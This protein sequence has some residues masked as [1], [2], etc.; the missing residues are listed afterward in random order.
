MA[1]PSRYRANPKVSN[2]QPWGYEVICEEESKDAVVVEYSSSDSDDIDFDQARVLFVKKD[3]SKRSEREQPVTK[4]IR[5]APDPL[6]GAYR[7]MFGPR[8]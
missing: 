4:E 6:L 5:P 8:F 3:R 7:H 1:H 2:E